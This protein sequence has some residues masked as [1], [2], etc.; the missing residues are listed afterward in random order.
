MFGVAVML[1]VVVLDYIIMRS[2]LNVSLLIF[3]YTQ[4]ISEYN[5]AQ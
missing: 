5:A 1:K 2:V 4:D 3:A